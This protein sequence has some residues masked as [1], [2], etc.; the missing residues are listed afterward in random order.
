M[1]PKQMTY[2]IAQPTMVPCY[3]WGHTRAFALPTDQHGRIRINLAGREAK[4]IVPR[5]QYED[6]CREIENLLRSLRREDGPPLVKDVIRTAASSSEAQNLMLP[7]LIVH[8]SDQAQQSPLRIKGSTLE[9]YPTGTKYT[10]QHDM[11]GFFIATGRPAS[12]NEDIQAKDLHRLLLA[13]LQNSRAA[14]NSSL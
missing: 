5:G 6:I 4:G 2:R 12:G 8:F 14:S 13:G 10:G 3:D 11:D 1:A 7:D 9:T